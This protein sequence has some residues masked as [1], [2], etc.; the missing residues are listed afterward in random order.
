MSTQAPEKQP[1]HTVRFQGKIRV[2][3][4][5]LPEDTFVDLSENGTHHMYATC[6]IDGNRGKSAHVAFPSYGNVGAS[7][8]QGPETLGTFA[9]ELD[10]CDTG[11]SN[12]LKIQFCMRMLDPDSQN[13]RSAEICMGHAWAD[14]MLQGETDR[15]RVKNQFTE[16][17]YIDVE[18]VAVNACDFR[19]HPG[20]AACL[21]KPLI[22]FSPSK[23][24]QLAE[25]NQDMHQLTNNVISVL[26]KNKALLS[27]EAEGFLPGLT[28]SFF[29]SFTCF[30]A[31]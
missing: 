11:D 14:K 28:R 12:A 5:G 18:M 24:A 26:K 6:W 21:W 30:C 17:N 27:N 3:T 7:C 2:F 10:Y 8:S 25:G 23:L 4:S 9:L 31:S 1:R 22:T 29:S 16:G 15:F 20:N 13:R 19:N